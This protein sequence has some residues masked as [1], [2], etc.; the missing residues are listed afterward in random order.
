MARTPSFAVPAALLLAVVVALAGPRAY[1]GGGSDDWHYLQAAR[2][3]A[4]HGFC[5][6]Q[7]HWWARWPLVWPLGRL[8]AGVGESRGVLA[9]AGLGWTLL[10]VG[11][12]AALL[13]RWAGP[14]AAIGG[15]ALLLAFPVLSDMAARLAV[16]TCELALALLGALLLDIGLERRD[17]RWLAAAG[18]ALGLAVAARTTSLALLPPAALVAWYRGGRRALLP[19][20]AGAL[21]PPL[22]EALGYAC[23][24]LDPL[25][26]WRLALHHTAIATQE[27]ARP[28]P[29]GEGPLLNPHWI[30]AWRPSAGI[31]WHWTVDPVVNL[32]AHPAF[33]PPALVAAGLALVHR[34]ALAPDRRRV[35]GLALFAGVWVLALAYGLAVD[36]KPRMFLPAA[37]ALA[38]VGGLALA[39]GW[40]TPLRWPGVALVALLFAHGVVEAGR[41]PD[42]AA[43][44][45]EADRLVALDAAGTA[46]D[47]TSRRALAFAPGVQA[48]AAP[49]RPRWQVTLA[50]GACPAGPL[51]SAWP[52]PP[53]GL[54]RWT[55]AAGIAPPPLVLCRFSAGRAASPPR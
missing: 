47:E 18:L 36:P 43:A 38:G 20:A 22:A 35:A 2:C 6:P 13:R 15:A 32:L 40:A 28:V 8:L 19:L 24:G 5:V 9:L 45:R 29:P 7:A 49:A 54:S 23:A 52:V 41:M 27:L 12:L 30:A 11:S 42:M 55:A 26:P 21:V 33:G 14:V 46:V 3:A 53:A 50:Q 44:E 16:D 37:A 31:H 1:V 51:S 39:R 48:L 4:T 34:R 25:L 10:A 17:R